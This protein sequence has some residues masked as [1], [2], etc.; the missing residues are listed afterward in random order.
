MAECNDYESLW[1]VLIATWQ[2][3]DILAAMPSLETLDLR[4]N[5]V[6]SAP[7]PPCSHFATV[8]SKAT[9]MVVLQ[10]GLA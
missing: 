2:V 7:Y 4:A 6:S 1:L 8:V 3:V 10:T 5:P 9:Y